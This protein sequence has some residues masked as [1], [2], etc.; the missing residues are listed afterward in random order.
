MYIRDD[1]YAF[2]IIFGKK[3]RDAFEV[4]RTEFFRYML[5]CYENAGT[6]HDGKWMFIDVQTPEQLEEVKKLILI[7]KKPNR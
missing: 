2:L 7:K 1:R 5:D 4:C 3:E 6:Y